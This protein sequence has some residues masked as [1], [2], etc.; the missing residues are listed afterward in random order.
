MTDEQWVDQSACDDETWYREME[1]AFGISCGSRSAIRAVEKQQVPGDPRDTI[2]STCVAHASM[3]GRASSLDRA[4][5]PASLDRPPLLSECGYHLSSYELGRL[6]R[7]IEGHV[8]SS[9]RRIG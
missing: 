1:Q 2:P 5:T 3:T 8:A 4:Q 6:H 7:L 9:I